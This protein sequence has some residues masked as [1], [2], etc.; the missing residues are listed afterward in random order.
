MIVRDSTPKLILGVLAC[1][2]TIEASAKNRLIIKYKPFIQTEN[3]KSS[4][5]FVKKNFKDRKK[6]KEEYEALKNS[7]L[8]E[9]VEV[10]TLMNTQEIDITSTSN[11][12]RLS[13]QWALGNSDGGIEAFEAWDSYKGSS[14]TVVA[15]VDTGIVSHS[16]I[17]SKILPGY[18][19]ISDN[20]FAND[21]DGRDSDP[22]DPGDWIAYG[23]SC[24]QGSTRNSSWHGTHVAGIIAAQSNNSKGVAGVNWNAKILPVR[25]LGKCGGYTS[26]IADAVKWAAGVAVSGAPTNANPASVINLSLGG[27]GPCSAYMQDAINQAKA[28]GAVVVVAAGN[29]SANLDTTDFTPANCQGVLV[30][31]SSTQNGY[32]SSFSNYGKIVD[33]SAPGGGNG[34]SVISLG[35]AG[36]TT[37]S[38]ESYVYQSGTSMAAPHVAGI[39]SLMKGVNP[40]L[41]P[42]QL[43]A[44]VKEAAKSF[45]W[46]SGCDEDKCGTGIA[47]A[48]RSIQLAAAESPDSTFE[49]DE[50]ASA[51]TAPVSSGPTLTT[52]TDSGGICGSVIYKDRKDTTSSGGGSLFLMLGFILVALRTLKKKNSEASNC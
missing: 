31:G 30:V 35:N 46:S 15:V 49:D 39:V 16:D 2:F 19:M 6:M 48:W 47:L 34:S 22:S 8:V 7:S 26:D 29:S 18:D 5:R 28:R 12:T 50:D 3:F 51:G 27:T 42:D 1:I 4:S 43:M 13:E 45:P 38:S 20:S 24:Y 21:G 23:D 33:V 44:L 25:A 11:D 52:S 36:S 14:S 32:R 41:Y 17:N 37:P 40:G 10:D 9:Y